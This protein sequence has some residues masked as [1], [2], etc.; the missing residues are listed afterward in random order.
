MIHSYML[1]MIYCMQV[2]D[3]FAIFML[4][5][6]IAWISF[7]HL[8]QK[9]MQQ[10]MCIIFSFIIVVMAYPYIQQI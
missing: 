3:A 5:R 10:H 9:H 6:L 7:R 4:P 1:D 2:C 8:S